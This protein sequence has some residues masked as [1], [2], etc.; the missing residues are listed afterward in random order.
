MIIKT[1]Q[2]LLVLIVFI[3]GLYLAWQ[4][5]WIGGLIAVLALLL[6]LSLF[7]QSSDADGSDTPSQNKVD[8]LGFISHSLRSPV[9]TMMA[10]QESLRI[11]DAVNEDPTLLQRLD[12]L[13]DYAERNLRCTDQLVNLL[14]AEGLPEL[15]RRPTDLAALAEETRDELMPLAQASGVTLQPLSID[16]ATTVIKLQPD[17]IQLAWDNL[18]NNA[19][20]YSQPAGEVTLRLYEADHFICLEVTDQ[21]IGMTADEVDSLPHYG[22][23]PTAPPD[24]AGAGLGL[25]LVDTIAR[26]HG[27]KLTIKSRKNAGSCF[28]LCLPAASAGGDFA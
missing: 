4:S 2:R 27:G 22:R 23:L 20:K 10:L 19:I 1:T 9:T 28:T 5:S 13:N 14:R 16:T 21:G 25:Q 7:F 8:R 18:L 24:L 3:L 6:G 15:A 12:Q 26:R 11:S 17:L